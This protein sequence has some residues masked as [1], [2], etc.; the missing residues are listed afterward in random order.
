MTKMNILKKIAASLLITSIILSLD[1]PLVFAFNI[2]DPGDLKGAVMDAMKDGAVGAMDTVMGDLGVDK[3]ELKNNVQVMNVSRQK[4]IPPQVTIT[5][6]PDSPM[7]GQKITATAMP[8]YFTNDQSQLYFTW[9]LKQ[10]GDT[11][12]IEDYKVKAMRLIAGGDFEWNM[13]GTYDIP[14]DTDSDGYQAFFGGQN[15][16]G[17]ASHCYANDTASGNDYEIPCVHAF[18]TNGPGTVGDGSFDLAEEKFWH[19]NPNSN[20]TSNGGVMDEAAVVGVGRN[21]LSWIYKPGDK[22]S[23]IV[24]GI[25]VDPTTYQDSSYKTMWAIPKNTDDSCSSVDHSALPNNYTEPVPAPTK[26][27]S[28]D[29]TNIDPTNPYWDGHEK[30]YIE[31]TTTTAYSYSKGSYTVTT[32]PP[33]NTPAGSTGDE[34]RQIKTVTTTTKDCAVTYPLLQAYLDP[35]DPASYNYSTPIN[36]CAASI[37]PAQ[38]PT[39]I[40]NPI[41]TDTRYG[42]TSS[43]SNFNSCIGA[44]FVDPAQGTLDKKLDVSLS[45]SPEAPM[46]DLSG[47]NADDLSVQS[48]VLNAENNNFINYTWGVAIGTAIDSE[49]WTALSSAEKKQIGLG[50][51]TGI[52]LQALKMKLNFNQTKTF[53]LKVTLRAKETTAGGTQKEGVGTVIIP[54]YNTENKIQVFP[55]TVSAGA[56]ANDKATIAVNTNSAMER[57]KDGMENV[58]CP[59]VKNEIVGL[60]TSI[61]H[62]SDYDLAWT[63]NGTSFSVDNIDNTKGTAYFPVLQDTDAKY[64]VS[65]SASSKN[66]ADKIILT[67]TF[68]VSDPEIFISAVN[69]DSK[70]LTCMPV[71]LGHYVDPINKN[72]NPDTADASLWPDYSE[73]S[74][75]ALQDSTVQ[76]QTTQ[77]TPSLGTLSW[78]FDG[79]VVTP[80][81][82]S[83]IGATVSADGKN[84]SFSANK[85]LGESYSIGVAALYTQSNL[86]KKALYEYWNVPSTDFYEK[87]VGK[88]IDIK[89][90]DHLSSGATLAAKTPNQKILASLFSA[91]PAYINFLFRVILTIL[92]ILFTTGLLFSIFPKQNQT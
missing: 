88:S 90:T 2:N 18:P 86:V 67:K 29:Y 76:L 87:P 24:E 61:P 43:T 73:T 68:A 74:F 57:C 89:V 49:D 15:Q 71:L 77:N 38:W 59:I 45:Y 63:L 41:V 25:S 12:G 32:T 20:D 9:L 54:V 72:P 70:H 51:L 34:I 4:K 37:T 47:D 21:T 44:N 17:K 40:I 69:T 48:S 23:V 33:S 42:T 83:E 66:S 22:V 8:T 58:L 65:L 80:D 60:K 11:G 16:K 75:E 19:T 79:T 6:T 10:K 62:L 14:S 36:T 81:N 7:P 53:Y 46:N 50:Q 28:V 92:L 39:S 30:S 35:A 52:G 3:K 5:F 56:G 91:V 13:P 85:I 55:V 64:T 26:A 31:V 78:V 82:A 27:N 84:I 1:A